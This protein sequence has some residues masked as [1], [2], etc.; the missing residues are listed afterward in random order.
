MYCCNCGTKLDDN[1]SICPE[2]GTETGKKKS[3]NEQGQKGFTAASLSKENISGKIGDFAD[4]V[5][6]MAG[7]DEHVEL[8]FADLFTDMLKKHSPEEAEELFIC[9]TSNTTP[10]IQDIA[11]EWP[12]PWLFLR[13]GAYLALTFAMLYIICTSF[14]N[15]NGLPGLMFVGSMIVPFMILVFMFEVNYPPLSCA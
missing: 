1:V 14:H 10:K 8:K 4:K 5:S 6:R 12:H 11:T 15:S 13:V 7:G 3:D 9:G 2:C